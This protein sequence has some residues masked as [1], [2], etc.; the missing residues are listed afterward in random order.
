MNHTSGTNNYS[1]NRFQGLRSELSPESMKSS[2]GGIVV[3]TRVRFET[4]DR[5]NR[6]DGDPDYNGLKTQYYNKW[7]QHRPQ[8]QTLC[9]SGI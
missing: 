1:S 5:N 4:G 2:K 7:P 9:R 6:A 8:S 3:A